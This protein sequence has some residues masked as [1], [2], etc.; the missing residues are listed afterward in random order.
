[1]AAKMSGS[2]A[3]L[4]AGLFLAGC[5]DQPG[6]HPHEIAAAAGPPPQAAQSDPD[7]NR[8]P[9]WY[10]GYADYQN[11]KRPNDP[12]SGLAECDLAGFRQED[13]DGWKA[14]RDGDP[15]RCPYK[16]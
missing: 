2:L 5:A 8:C 12:D 11:G 16:R 13:L 6:R 14:A 9:C 15:K 1:M 10:T 7:P 3:F 4:L